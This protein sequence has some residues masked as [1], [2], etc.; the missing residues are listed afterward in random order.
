MG[1]RIEEVELGDQSRTRIKEREASRKKQSSAKKARRKYR[2]LAGDES[3]A[4]TSDV[5]HGNDG[6]EAAERDVSEFVEATGS[7]QPAKGTHDAHHNEH[8]HRPQS[9]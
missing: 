4:L 3:D 8:G 5:D 1:E 9:K 7:L 6:Q 2:A